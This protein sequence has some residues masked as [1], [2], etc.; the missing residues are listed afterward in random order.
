[1]NINKIKK[2]LN[3]GRTLQDLELR[4]TYYARTANSNIN[5]QENYL[6]SIIDRTD[7]WTYV[8]G[9]ADENKSGLD[10]SHRKG[11]LT[12]V[13][14]LKNKNIDVVVIKD[15]ARISR[16]KLQSVEHINKIIDNGVVVYSVA[17]N[18]N[19]LDKM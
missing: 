2:E 10:I 8:R 16:D 1:M 12:M 17:E 6:K 7:K 18:I 11:L 9:Y 14:D 4:V 19:I 3:S 5:E 15:I 13:E